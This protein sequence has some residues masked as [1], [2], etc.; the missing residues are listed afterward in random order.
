MCIRALRP[1]R[2]PLGRCRGSNCL[3]C[4]VVLCDE[5]G[6]DFGNLIL[7]TARELACLFENLLETALSNG[8][9]WLGRGHAEQLI[10]AH[11]ERGS[12]LR[13]DLATRGLLSALPKRNVALRDPEL[14]GEVIL[15][16]TGGAARGG[17]A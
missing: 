16:K 17:K 12:E 11:A 14:S 3:C 8:A 10:K 7:L 9:F 5:S 6:D 13:K 4:L 1:L 2:A 15:T